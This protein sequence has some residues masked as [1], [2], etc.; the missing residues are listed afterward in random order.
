MPKILKIIII[1]AVI[2]LI[3]SGTFYFLNRGGYASFKPTDQQVLAQ[4]KKIILLPDNVTPN[5]AIVMNADVLKK[6]QPNFFAD[7]KNGDRLIIYPDLVVLYDYNANKI[8]KVGPVQ[9][10]KNQ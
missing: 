2:L 8:I 1:L 7:A 10:A 5:M 4:L 9:A 3:V 6:Q